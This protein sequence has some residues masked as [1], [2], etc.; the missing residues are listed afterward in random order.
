MTP[1]ALKSRQQALQMFSKVSC[2]CLHVG[3]KER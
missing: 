3:P 1:V 2:I